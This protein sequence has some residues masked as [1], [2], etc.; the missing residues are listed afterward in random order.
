MRPLCLLLAGLVF[1]W[2][3]D[4][5]AGS[6]GLARVNE[7][8]IDNAALLQK[9]RLM[10]PSQRARA[11]KERIL[12]DLIN[13]ELLCQ[14]AKKLQ[15]NNTDEY[16]LRVDMAKRNILVSM[17]IQRLLEEK[18]TEENQR[19]FYEQTKDKWRG[20]GSVRLSIILVKTEEEA[21]DILRRAKEGEDF[22]ELAKKYSIGKFAKKGG[23]AGYMTHSRMGPV[24][25]VALSTKV[26][27]IGEL[28]KTEAGYHIV[29]VTDKRKGPVLNFEDIKRNIANAYRDKL[30]AETLMEIRKSSK[31]EV[32]K[33]QLEDLEI[34]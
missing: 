8:V 7:A 14:E 2:S 21:N 20:P 13:E 1:W 3:A 29:K 9:I 33:K 26:G 5:Y 12:E 6:E 16:R 30:I 34:D 32:N 28:V 25:K 27:E 17:Y 22:A 31:V 11:D 4:A 24:R 19:E 18:N 15:L 10:P 23:D